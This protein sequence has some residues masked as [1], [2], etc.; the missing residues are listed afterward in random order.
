MSFGTK[1]YNGK[2]NSS[3]YIKQDGKQQKRIILLSVKHGGAYVKAWTRMPANETGTPAF[4]D[5]FT[6]DGSNSMN[7]DVYRH[8]LRAQI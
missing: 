2:K 8:F 1:F 6:A 3:F 4:A 5:G 7:A